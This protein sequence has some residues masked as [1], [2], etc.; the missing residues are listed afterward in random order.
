MET[1][2]EKYFKANE[3]G[4]SLILDEYCNNN[5]RRKKICNKEI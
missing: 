1:L 5:K 3:K 2:R 4:K